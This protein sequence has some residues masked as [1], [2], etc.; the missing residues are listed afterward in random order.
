MRKWASA[1]KALKLVNR[2]QNEA[3]VGK[4]SL[5]EKVDVVQV[6]CKLVPPELNWDDSHVQSMPQKQKH[7]DNPPDQNFVFTT[8]LGVST[9]GTTW[10][11]DYAP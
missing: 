5:R 6:I 7:L 2:I 9:C 1:F 4:Y 3:A 10:T 8:G 11:C